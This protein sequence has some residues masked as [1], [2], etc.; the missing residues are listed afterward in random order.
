MSFVD[1]SLLVLRNFIAPSLR[2]SHGLVRIEKELRRIR[3]WPFT[4][5]AVLD[6]L[7]DLQRRAGRPDLID[8]WSQPRSSRI[9]VGVSLPIFDDWKKASTRVEASLEQ[10]YRRLKLKVHPDCDLVLYRRLFAEYPE[11]HWS[12]DANGSFFEGEFDR[13]LAW[14][15]LD[16][17]SFEQPVPPDDLLL[18]ERLRG[19]RPEL[20]ICLD[21]SLS[22]LG[23]VA[24]LYGYGLLDEVNLKPGR[25]GGQRASLAI[26]EFCRRRELAVW[27]GG[28]FETGVGR[29][30][31]LRLAS[32]MPEARAHDL[33][34][35]SRYFARDLVDPPI[36]MGADGT[37]ATPA[38]PVSVDW[39]LVDELTTERIDLPVKGD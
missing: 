35:S 10:G 20:R 5:A 28:M 34:P 23:M 19:R 12:F 6:A 9:P 18:L 4:C 8:R 25:V 13:L 22:G 24:L 33:S 7:M 26:L 16:P 39:D 2:R 38:E 31:N 17:G 15:D 1:G 29:T 27:V 37:V 36:E 3:G 32:L 21:E 14:C 11:V 30:Q